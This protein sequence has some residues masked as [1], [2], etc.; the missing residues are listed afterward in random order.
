MLGTV[1]FVDDDPNL[2]ALLGER[3]RRQ[4]WEVATAG[5]AADALG[6]LGEDGASFAGA[7]VDI[8]LGNDSGLDLCRG[9]RD[10]K[11]GLPVIIITG[12]DDAEAAV[13]A[14]RAGAFD[15]IRK[16]VDIGELSSTLER[17]AHKSRIE[18]KVRLLPTRSSSTGSLRGILGHSASMR[19]VCSLVERIAPIDTSVLITGENGTGKE[20]IARALHEQSRRHAGSFIAV[21]CAAI[22]ESLMESELFGHVKGA[23]TDARA[24]RKG[25]FVQAGGGTL[26]LDEIGELP[27]RLQAKLLRVLQERV[28]R[29]VGSDREVPI[30]VRLLSAT[31]RNLT[32]AIAE[33]NFREDLYYRVSVIHVD[34]PPLRAREDDLLVLAQYFVERFA[35][36]LGKAVAG[37]TPAVAEALL[38][39][40]WPGNV[41]ELQ[42]SVE[43]A[44]AL[45]RH[46]RLTVD[47]L[48]ERLRGYDRSELA[49]RSLA[50]PTAPA[51]AAALG[52]VERQHIERVLEMAGGNKSEAA[53]ILGLSR[54]T[55]HRRVARGQLRTPSSKKGEVSS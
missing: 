17:A 10:A 54:R 33:G 28:V 35:T 20:M 8:R 36:Q 18:E 55:L 2:C 27:V 31:N 13:G 39:Y 19:E 29:P 48:P 1:L 24:D 52:D 25:L 51:K 5:S 4:G 21:N 44:V 38:A 37:F 50:A 45:A 49:G 34:L 43:H 32:K 7:V 12:D 46:D 16:P 41:R 53:R 3:L 42:N 11:P 6:R 30:D 40:P 47:D 15:F 9:I 22:P 14:L 23:F 26:F